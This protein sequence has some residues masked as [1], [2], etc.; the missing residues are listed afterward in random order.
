MVAVDNGT[1]TLV[2][3]PLAALVA[4]GITWWLNRGARRK[5]DN[6]LQTA[7]EA[8]SKAVTADVKATSADKT[9]TAAQAATQALVA[10]G[11][12]SEQLLRGLLKVV[13]EIQAEHARCKQDI[14]ELRSKYER[15]F[16]LYSDE[17]P[18]TLRDDP[19]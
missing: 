4:G 8:H 12:P 5:A 17:H 3:A 9:A 15:L 7:D 14:A 10:V 2:S 11:V 1:A 18:E 19:R 16:S 13:G 6:A